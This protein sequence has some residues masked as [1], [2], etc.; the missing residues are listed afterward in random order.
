MSS[1]SGRLTQLDALRGI[2]AALVVVHHALLILTGE[3]MPYVTLGR[4]EVI[5]FFVLSAFV[6]TRSLEKQSYFVFAT[7]RVFR[8]GLP[9]CAALIFALG[10]RIVSGPHPIPD[11][12]EWFNA[13]WQTTLTFKGFMA[14]VLMRGHWADASLNAVLWSLWYETRLSFLLPFLVLFTKRTGRWALVTFVAL[15]VVTSAAL[16]P[17]SIRG[18]HRLGRFWS[19]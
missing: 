16:P 9:F 6:L 13:P 5:L 3:P 15:A 19:T 11:Q 10:L 12:S 17:E 18:R 14:H 8:L 1:P 2:A 7:R 4:P